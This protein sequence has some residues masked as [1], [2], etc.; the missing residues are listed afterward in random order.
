MAEN[1]NKN[2]FEERERGQEML[3]CSRETFFSIKSY[4]PKS[5]PKVYLWRRATEFL[6]RIL[7]VLTFGIT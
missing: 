2:D 5:V 6:F 4:S 7:K 3:Q 1:V